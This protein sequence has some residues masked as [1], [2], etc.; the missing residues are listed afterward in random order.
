M[1][2]T[3]LMSCAPILIFLDSVV[4]DPTC[5]GVPDKFDLAGP[6]LRDTLASSLLEGRKE[7]R[8]GK[9]TFPPGDL[10]MEDQ[11]MLQA[12]AGVG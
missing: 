1:N 2:S 5:R 7:G 12:L 10:F 11:G 8:K 9:T 3:K 4:Y 6:S